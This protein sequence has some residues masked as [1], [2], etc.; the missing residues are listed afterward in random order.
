MMSSAIKDQKNQQFQPSWIATIAMKIGTALQHFTS[1]WQFPHK[2]MSCNFLIQLKYCC[3]VKWKLKFRSK[4]KMEENNP[5]AWKS[6]L[7]KMIVNTQVQHRKAQERNLSIS[8][9]WIPKISWYQSL[10]I[11][12]LNIQMLPTSGY[13]T[14]TDAPLLHPD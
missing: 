8:L 7:H 1:M 11:K 13:K 14:A 4:S 5:C 9:I 2:T 10:N 3:N 12:T 6:F